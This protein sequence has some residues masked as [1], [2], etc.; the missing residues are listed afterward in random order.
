MTFLMASIMSGVMGAVAAGGFSMQW[1]SMWPRQFIVAWPIAFMLTM[2][3]WPTSLKLAG[4][5][6]K[7]AAKVRK[8]PTIAGE[9][10]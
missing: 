7:L 10:A 8:T 2:V 4:Q 3:A 9:A 6:T 1:L 5:T